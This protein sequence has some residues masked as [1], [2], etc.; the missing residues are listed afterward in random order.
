MTDT[1]PA[2]RTLLEEERDFLLAS[3]DDLEREHEAGDLDDAD[4]R[5][6]KADYTARAAAVIRR[7]DGSTQ[8]PLADEADGSKS[9]AWMWL[10]GV[11]IVAVL[12]GV[13]IAQ[14]SGSRGLN[15]TITGDIRI[16]TREL[17]ADAQFRISEGDLDGAIGVYDE[18]LELSPSNT[19]A[20]AYKAWFLRIQGDVEAARPFVED[21]VDIDPSY[22]DARVFATAIAL[23]VGDVEAAIGHLEA[24]DQLDA[25]PFIEQLVVQQG[26]RDRLNG[27]AQADALDRIAPIAIVDDPPQFSDTE[28]VTAE[29]LLAAEALAAQGE[30]FTA[31]QLVEWVIESV[32]DDVDALAGQGWLLARS[33]TPDRLEP[34]EIGLTFLDRALALEPDHLEAL[35]YRAF[36]HNFLGNVDAAAADLAAFDAAP[37]RPADLR[38][39]ISAFGLREVLAG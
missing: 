10:V 17:L 6:L 20:L 2:D 3:L 26:L 23:D 13:L 7:L 19:E 15:E 39:L 11:T 16:T 18:V 8:P 36:V 5:N 34:A 22:P 29:V 14:F 12:A 9:R 25:P 21:A 24:F 28:F 38:D 1:A 4:Y 31:L 37:V 32:P 35:V 27:I 30:L 33:A